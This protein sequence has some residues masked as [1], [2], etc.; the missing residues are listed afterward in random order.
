MYFY[1]TV[2]SYSIEYNASLKHFTHIIRI[3]EEFE[4]ISEDLRPHTERVMKIEVAPWI[5]DYVADMD[6]LYTELKLEKVDKR[7]TKEGLIKLN[8]Y[9]QLFEESK[10]PFLKIPSCLK[11]RR[12]DLRKPG[13]SYCLR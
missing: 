10:K 11:R 8:N 13:K 5:K 7:P 4:S 6:K 3:G 1:T 12:K 9:N 2:F